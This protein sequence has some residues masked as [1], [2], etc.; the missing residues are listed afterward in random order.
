[1]EKA[2]V[3]FTITPDNSL[4]NKNKTFVTPPPPHPIHHLAYWDYLT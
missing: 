4:R 1:M 3:S 2:I